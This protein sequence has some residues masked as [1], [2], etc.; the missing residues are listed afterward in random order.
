MITKID[1]DSGKVKE[2]IRDMEKTRDTIDRVRSKFAKKARLNSRIEHDRN[3]VW[4][5]VMVK[6]KGERSEAFD[7][8]HIKDAYSLVSTDL[9][10]RNYDYS[11]DAVT[12]TMRQQA[13]ATALSEL[14]LEDPETKARVDAILTRV[15]KI[16]VQRDKILPEKRK[17]IRSAY[18]QET[19]NGVKEHLREIRDDIDENDVVQIWREVLA[20]A[21]HE[22]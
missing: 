1:I 5:R 11:W 3:E 22:A 20:E 8:D 9:Q 21:V 15:A 12:Q 17:Q 14:I 19:V 10:W 7:A 13:T 6:F 18:V 16:M 2:I 4:V